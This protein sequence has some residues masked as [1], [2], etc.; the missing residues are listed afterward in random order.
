MSILITF[1]FIIGYIAISFEQKIKINKAATAMLLA[2]F[3]WAII[4]IDYHPKD[5]QISLQLNDSLA[6]ISQILFF[7]IGVMAIVEIIDTYHGFR[8]LSSIFRT[9]RKVI[10][11][12]FFTIITFFL[13]AFLDNVTTSIIMITLLRQIIP[14]RGD[15]LFFAGMIILSANAGGAWT[16]IGDVTTTMLWIKGYVSS[17]KIIQ[18]IFIPSVLSMLVPL[19]YIS[20]FIKGDT[21]TMSI[22]DREEPIEGSRGVFALG[23]TALLLVPVLKAAFDIPPYLGVLFGL[24]VLWLYTDIK[25]NKQEIL[26]VP[27]ILSKVDFTSI[28]FLLG[29]LL[30]VSAL[31]SVGILNSLA[32]FLDNVFRDKNII[33]P[34]LGVI[35]AVVDNIPLTAGLMGMYDINIYP[36]DS[37][38]WELTAFCVGTGGSLLIIGSAAGIVVMGMEQISFS[39]YLKKMTIPAFFGFIIGIISLNIIFALWSH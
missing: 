4:L 22:P 31:E 23:V 27:R 6:D 33:I 21:S 2:V 3:C 14:E 7:L 5:S 37:K 10:L 18:F 29:I 34:I 39:W 16:P 30:A 20:F 13:S 35:S 19:I 1:L 38:I 15:R 8:I 12:W 26:K 32:H 25:N 9:N 11:L 17:G 28:L 24:G 36:M